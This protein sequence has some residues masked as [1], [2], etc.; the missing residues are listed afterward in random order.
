MANDFKIKFEYKGV[1]QKAALSTRNKVI[2]AQK[3]AL[4]KQSDQPVNK[5]FINSIKGLNDSIKKLIESNQSL[6]REISKGRSGGGSPADEEGGGGS[7]RFGRAAMGIG[8]G[9][10]ALGVTGVLLS[11][12]NQIGNAYIEKMSQQFGNVGIAGNR[13]SS[14]GGIYTASEVSSGMKAY[15]TA[16]GR[17]ANKAGVNK[18]AAQMGA[19]YGLSLDET[20]G[21]AGT[22]E[23]AGGNYG[24]TVNYGLG[25]GIESEMPLFMSGIAG[26]LENAVTSGIDASNMSKDIGKEIANIAMRTPGKSVAAAMGIVKSY[27]GV[28]S[29][30]ERG[31]MGESLDTMYA[32]QANKNILMKNLSDETYRKQLL[33]SGYI[34]QEQYDKLK[35]F[36]PGSSYSDLQS[37]IGGAAAH[38]LFKKSAAETGPDALVMESMRVQQQQY[39]K[40]VKGFQRWSTVNDQ[41]SGAL[42]QSQAKSVWD[43]VASGDASK[44]SEAGKKIKE[45]KLGEVMGSDAAMSRQKEIRRDQMVYDFG[46]TFADT[47]MEMEKQLL[48]LARNAAP[49]ATKSLK[50]LG[51]AVQG[52]TK[53][54]NK[55]SKMEFRDDFSMGENY[56][57][58]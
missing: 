13:M 33:D 6:A 22:F 7:K 11:K 29:S 39:G 34:D 49:L 44:I 47:T 27:G 50:M 41:M 48:D 38:T 5:E 26:I 52:L 36:G 31:K 54:I 35:S 57:Y 55:A 46:K 21:Q 43:A 28:K 15:G 53:L 17:F 56:S 30:L 3:N 37:S 58:E 18:S 32:A 14:W 25:S 19:I 8:I 23:R 1:G 12:I 42:G 24:A 20:L 2:Q 45:S 51:E 9:A 4:K 10:G 40:D 16:T